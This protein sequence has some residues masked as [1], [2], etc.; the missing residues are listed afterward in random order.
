MKFKEISKLFY[1]N[2]QMILQK[3]NFTRIKPNILK[4]IDPEF[5]ITKTLIEVG[6]RENDINF[7]GVYVTSNDKVR[8]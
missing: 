8:K 7:V 1:K 2:Y 5:T 6:Q 4:D 3:L